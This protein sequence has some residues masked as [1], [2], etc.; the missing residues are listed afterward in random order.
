MKVQ[1]TLVMTTLLTN[2]THLSKK[3]VPVQRAMKNLFWNRRHWLDRKSS[4]SEIF[5]PV[6]GNRLYTPFFSHSSA[7]NLLFF[8]STQIEKKFQK[9]ELTTNTCWN[10]K[11]CVQVRNFDWNVFLV[12]DSVFDFVQDRNY[13][14]NTSQQYVDS[15]LHLQSLSTVHTNINKFFMI[16]FK[17]S[18]KCY[19]MYL[20][21]WKRTSLFGIYSI[22]KIKFEIFRK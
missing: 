15:T 6:D 16:W 19:Q 1:K 17:T 10:L 5:S 7:V 21:A 3:I 22:S 2:Q 8:F 9:P 13:K 14:C 11:F 20:Y 18:V 12:S 4:L